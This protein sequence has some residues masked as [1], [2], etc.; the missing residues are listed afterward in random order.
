MSDSATP[1]TG[2][3]KAP[4]SME[5]S[6]QEYWH[7]QLFP[8]P[9]DLPNPGIEVGSPSLRGD[10][11]PSEPPGKGKVKQLS[12]VR[13][14]VTHGLQPTRKDPLSMGFSRQGYQ[15]GL[16]LLHDNLTSAVGNEVTVPIR[17]SWDTEFSVGNINNRK[18]KCLNIQDVA[19][20]P[21]YR[22]NMVGYIIHKYLC[23]QYKNY[24]HSC[25]FFRFAFFHLKE[26]SIQAP[27]NSQQID[28][29]FVKKH[30]ILD[31]A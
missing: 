5:F 29:T 4:L 9:G 26:N 23:N 25:N 1:W 14:F 8:S 19:T 6:R 3:C 24:I 2:T 11:L 30:Q 18:P 31:S 28:K 27:W 12:C 7:G 16:P 13:L 17:H 15:S 10:S 22:K 21:Y 20:D